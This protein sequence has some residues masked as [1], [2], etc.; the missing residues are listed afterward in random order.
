[1]C[2][3]ITKEKCVNFPSK[4]NIINCVNSNPDGFAMSYNEDG[5]IV[6]FKTL[7]AREFIA[8]YERV[9]ESHS[10]YNTAMI[11]HARIATHGSVKESN[12]HCWHS[13]VL[14]SEIS[15]AHNGILSIKA[16]GDMTDSE[17]FL[18][19]YLQPC[20]KLSEFLSTVERY[21]GSSKFALL[22]TDGNIMRFGAF[23]EERGVQYSNYSFRR[24]Q[25]RCADPR[26]W[27]QLAV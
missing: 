9:T 5:K 13:E 2:I 25:S 23:I 7:D 24:Y 16:E 21:I 3:L 14:G 11:I 19:K 18:R 12:C 1:M 15:F 8:E 20:R 17:T 10:P 26:L 22:D 6:T 4:R 27:P